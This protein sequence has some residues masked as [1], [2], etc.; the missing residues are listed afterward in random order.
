MVHDT[1]ECHIGLVCW[2]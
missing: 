2:Q 1:L